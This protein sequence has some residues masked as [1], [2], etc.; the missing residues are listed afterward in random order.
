ML[1]HHNP[2]YVI[3][4]LFSLLQY[5]V[6]DLVML[7]LVMLIWF[8]MIFVMPLSWEW[9]SWLKWL[10]FAI[11]DELDCC[12]DRMCFFK[13]HP[14]GRYEPVWFQMLIGTTLAQFRNSKLKWFRSCF[15]YLSSLSTGVVSTKTHNNGFKNPSFYKINSKK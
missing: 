10:K 9:K 12:M 3:S 11:T 7:I 8:L 5:N 1:N 6:T 13:W 14:Y 4:D 15:C 2:S